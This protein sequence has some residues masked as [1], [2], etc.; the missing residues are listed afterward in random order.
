MSNGQLLE[1][2]TL[3]VRQPKV[4][5]ALLKAH[6][7][8]AVIRLSIDP[9]RPSAGALS[10]QVDIEWVGKGTRGRAT[11]VRHDIGWSGLQGLAEECES[12]LLA[13]NEVDL[14]EQAAIAVMAILIH[15]LE[16]GVIERVLQIGS[17]GDYLVLTT[18][19]RQHDQV[20][21]SGVKD[22]TDGHATRRRLKDKSN[23]VLSHAARGFASVT[24]FSHPPGAEVRSC[25]HYVRKRSR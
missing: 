23:Q 19:A 22:D 1:F 7:L 14:T 25:L 20:E 2:A 6:A 4:G 12:Y 9:V 5:L 10:R 13:V 11:T 8:A 18:G 3:P 17:G 16:G 24:T 21:V 15:E